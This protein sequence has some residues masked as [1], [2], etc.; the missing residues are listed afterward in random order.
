M[1]GLFQAV[2]DAVHGIDNYIAGQ[3]V[4]KLMSPLAEAEVAEL[5]VESTIGFGENTDAAGDAL[6]LLGGELVYATGRTLVPPYK[7]TTLTR[8][9]DATIAKLH[10]VGSLVFDLSHN[11]SAI[12]HVKRGLFV[13]TAI[14]VDLDVIG[15]NLGLTKCSGFTEAQWRAVI[16]AVAYLP[17]QTRDAFVQ[18]LTALVGSGNY[19]L[20]EKLISDPWK[21]FVGI[22]VV[23][24]TT[25]R[26]RFCLNGGEPK[27]TTGLTTVL[28]TYP[29]NHVIGV[30][31]DSIRSRRGDRDGLTNYYTAG[32]GGSFV[33]STI[34][35]GASP[36]AI[37]T[38]VIIDYGAFAA[39]YLA[40]NETVL[41]DGDY[42][43]YLSD[44][45]LT[46]K[47]LLN[48]IRAAGVKVD[49]TPVY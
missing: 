47:C 18:T 38:A 6:L 17:K 28:T 41:D 5:L 20:Q 35:L 34:T 46:V 49:V 32:A 31:L 11:F 25:L 16:K 44:P 48:Q 40:P 22:K 9:V 42:Y 26:G 8:A 13:D 30:Y 23:V 14:G 7:F 39:H 36:G 1:A 19:T 15:R 3:A 10:P 33:G 29:I 45:T 21:V 24:A 12:D 4:T 37:G 43:A 2:L 27:L